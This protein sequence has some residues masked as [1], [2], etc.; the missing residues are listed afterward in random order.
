MPGRL[1]TDAKRERLNRFPENASRE[2]IRTYFT[3]THKDLSLVDQRRGDT[4]RIGFA[5]QLLTLRYLGFIP[6][7]IHSIH[8]SVVEFVSHQLDIP[9]VALSNYGSRTQTRTS[10]QQCIEGY[11]GYRSATRVDLEALSSW[12][13][14]RA[15]EHDKPSLLFQLAT[16]WLQRQKLVRV[17]ITQLE[18]RVVTARQAASQE[19][20]RRLQPI[21]TSEHRTFL[22]GL[23]QNSPQYGS[24]P[25]TWLR[26][27]A[28]TNSPAAIL[29]AL[30]K[31]DLLN[32]KVA[33]RKWDVSSLNPNRVK[34]LAQFAK[35][36]SNQAL[37]PGQTHTF[38][39]TLGIAQSSR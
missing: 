24:T 20:F 9:V 11:L 5:L 37:Q 1:L 29:N 10:H 16:A 36:A 32:S 22:D 38:L 6:D 19:T 27:H 12:L 3:L 30:A 33:V 26:R 39:N 18:R 25:L 31:L 4:N 21:L 8:T 28:T 23:L 15:M 2:D 35:R 7:D 14:E 13:V 17:G 34:F